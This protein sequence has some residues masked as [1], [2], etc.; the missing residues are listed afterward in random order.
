MRV[1]FIPHDGEY[2]YGAN[3]SL[4]NLLEG[5]KTYGVDVMVISP[6]KGSLLSTLDRISVPYVVHPFA[7]WMHQLPYRGWGRAAPGVRRIIKRAWIN[8]RAVPSI[9]RIMSD[10]QADIVYTNTSVIPIG[11]DVADRL[12]IPHVW[13]LREFGDLD[14]NIHP[15]WGKHLF[16]RKIRSSAATISVSRALQQHILG[17]VSDSR[18]HVIYNGVASQEYFDSLRQRMT[19]HYQTSH[20]A[21]F[22]MV[23]AISP[24]KGQYE[25]IQA[26][27]QISSV[28]PEGRLSIAGTGEEDYVTACKK[29]ADALGIMDRV[30]FLGYVKN[31]LDL[32]MEASAVLMCSRSEAMGR[33]TAEAMAAG[34]P[35]IGFDNAGTSELIEH[36]CN[37]LLYKDVPDELAA[38]MLR[39][40][41]N[42]AWGRTLGENGWQIARSKFTI[43]AYSSQVYSVLTDILKSTHQA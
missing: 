5:L 25:A 36:E 40:A 42:P 38:N 16:I 12:K 18:S 32:Y 4:V 2:K 23:G 28:I 13:H 27:G 7:F 10:W 43:E 29:A 8:L 1:V 15:D 3:M 31:P 33:V 30:N 20:N 11:R 26:L 6:E 41:M 14:Q 35:V 19:Y 37:G 22:L 17:S 21:H 39:I 9:A 24:S 34:R